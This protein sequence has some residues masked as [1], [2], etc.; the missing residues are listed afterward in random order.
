MPNLP[1]RSRPS[2]ALFA[3]AALVSIALPPLAHAAKEPKKRVAVIEF[4]NNV[5]NLGRD[6][7]DIG[8]GMADTL[9]EALIETD[10]FVVLERINLE[11]VVVE[12]N[13]DAVAP[14]NPKVE[15]RLT[16]AQALIRGV[17]TH[18]EE[19]GG[20][21]GG[22]SVAGMQIGGHNR[23]V[24]IKVNIRVIDSVTAQ[25]IASKTV[26]GVARIRSLKLVGRTKKG[27]SADLGGE[28]TLPIGDA[29]DA[30]VVMAVEEIVNGMERIPWQGTVARVSGSQIFINAGL[31]ENVETGLQL[32]VF[33]KG[34]TL[35]DYETNEDL[36]SLDEEIGIIEVEQV[37]PRFAVARIL[38]G[39]GFAP[40]N[41]VR[42]VESF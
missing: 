36:G 38:E 24:V 16:S 19:V 40:G 29:A 34:A 35:I 30:A 2:R 41:I 1:S 17:I 7:G 22:L 25:V 18:A 42:P 14:A 8:R 31:Q 6:W 23:K 5:R 13:L 27:N 9:V 26:E 32:R 28:R 4:E 3:L 12:Q 33:E 21:G 10:K 37:S 20:E 39:Q 15:A 11:D